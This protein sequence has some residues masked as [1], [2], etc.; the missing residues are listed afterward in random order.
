MARTKPAQSR[1]GAQG[2]VPAGEGLEL[3]EDEVEVDGERGEKTEGEVEDTECP[4]N[5]EGGNPPCR[6]YH[7]PELAEEEE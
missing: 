3:G 5:Q 4:I 2:E 6:K 1:R 7:D